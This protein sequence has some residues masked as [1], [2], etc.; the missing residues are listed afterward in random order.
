MLKIKKPSQILV[1][2][3][4]L[5]SLF[6]SFVLTAMMKFFV[7]FI[8]GFHFVCIVSGFGNSFVNLIYRS[9]AFVNINM[10]I[11]TILVPFGRTYSLNG[12]SCFFNTLFTHF[13]VSVYR[14]Y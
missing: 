3:R 9:F 11:L 12:I 4:L 5:Y 1:L 7:I 14:N 6:F 10:N 8:I 2:R 13:A